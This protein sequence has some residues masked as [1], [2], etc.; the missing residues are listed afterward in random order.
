MSNHLTDRIFWKEY[1]KNYQYKKVFQHYFFDKYI[2][3]KERNTS[4]EIGGFP[5]SMS[6]YLYK[7][8]G[9]FVSL[10]DFYIDKK[11]INQL[12]E[13]NGIPKNT[14]ECIESDFFKFQSEKKYDMVFSLGFIE[15]FDDTYDVIKR[16]VDL[17]SD[18]GQLLII[19]PNFRGINGLFQKVFDYKNF[20]AHNLNS[21]VISKL[22]NISLDLSLKNI[23]VEYA[24]KPMIWLEPKAAIGNRIAR[25]FVKCLSYSLK[26]FPIKSKIFSPY[27]VIKAN[28]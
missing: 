23:I 17:L 24:G 12:E 28:K 13:I 8:Y 19:L 21:M 7:K 15:H 9:F 22:E 11:I 1:W 26:L 2:D 18:N 14:I 4:I 5:G 3:I 6:I 25:V 20:K 27:I 10:L 16:H